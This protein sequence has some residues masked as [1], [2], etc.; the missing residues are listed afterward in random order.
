MRLKSFIIILALGIISLAGLS[1]ADAKRAVSDK[2]RI[3]ALEAQILALNVDLEGEK[4]WASEVDEELQV[5][6][7]RTLDLNQR[8]IRVEG[9]GPV[10]KL[11]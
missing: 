11:H 2:Q 7:A 3:E 6:N 8:L 5:F 9:R 10:A 1:A 4:Q